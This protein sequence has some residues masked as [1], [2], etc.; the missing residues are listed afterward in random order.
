MACAV[1][2]PRRHGA[3]ISGEAVVAVV[4]HAD[5]GRCRARRS[6]APDRKIPRVQAA[7]IVVRR[8]REHRGME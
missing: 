1:R 8:I 5:R 2:R 3:Q 4:G 7:E 6:P